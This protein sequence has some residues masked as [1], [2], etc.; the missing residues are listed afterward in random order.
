MR[1]VHSNIPFL[2]KSCLLGLVLWADAGQGGG[3]Q[4]SSGL[5]PLQEELQK[6]LPAAAGALVGMDFGESGFGSGVIVSKDGLIFSAAHVTGG[7]NR[8]FAVILPDGRR[9]R[10]ITLGVNAEFDAAMAQITTPGTYDFIPLQEKLPKTGEWVFALGH[11]GGY[12]AQRG[13]V[14][15]LGKVIHALDDKVRTDCKLIGGDSGGP[16]FNMKGELI[17][18]HSRVGHVLEDNV[19]VPVPLFT[20]DRKALQEGK[21]IGEGPFAQ[22]IPGKLGAVVTET[23]EGLE[24]SDLSSYNT[25]LKEK[26]IILQWDGNKLQ[27]RKELEDQLKASYA[28]QKVTLSIKREGQEQQIPFILKTPPSMDAIPPLRI[29]DFF[30]L[31]EG[32]ETEKQ[33]EAGDE[34]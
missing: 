29:P 27:T 9:V 20:K 26:D 23:P 3:E 22:K 5:V 4:A 17:G 7:V 8:P 21:W 16:L 32:K 2:I 25:E 24:L 34:E 11:S 13:Y 6:S 28:G 14:V 15:R 31:P 33:K 18:I 19:H 30:D 1:K 12:D 10:G